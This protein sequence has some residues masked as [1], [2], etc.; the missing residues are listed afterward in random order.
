[1]ELGVPVALSMWVTLCIREPVFTIGGVRAGKFWFKRLQFGKRPRSACL[2]GESRCRG[3][4]TAA[5]RIAL[6]EVG[7]PQERAFPFLSWKALMPDVCRSWQTTEATQWVVARLG[8]LVEC[9]CEWL[10]L[11]EECWH[12]ARC[13]SRHFSIFVSDFNTQGIFVFLR[14]KT[15]LDLF[16][17]PLQRWE[18]RR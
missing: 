17:H 10:P 9:R 14:K 11:G 1:M 6:V 7:S 5:G 16:W 15:S 18:S 8:S 2:L 12:R 3:G 13:G 4:S